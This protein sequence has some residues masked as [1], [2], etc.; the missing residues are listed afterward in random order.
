ML[1]GLRFSVDLAIHA[2][3]QAPEP[4]LHHAVGWETAAKDRDFRAGA[5]ACGADGDVGVIA[6]GGGGLGVA[7]GLELDGHGGTLV[8]AAVLRRVGVDGYQAIRLC[9]YGGQHYGRLKRAQL[10]GRAARVDDRL[11]D[12]AVTRKHLDG[13]MV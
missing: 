8:N 7:V 2:R 11:A 13:D 9:C 4:Y 1:S 5:S 6:T 10:P 3:G 12:R